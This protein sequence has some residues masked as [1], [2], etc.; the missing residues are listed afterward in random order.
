MH[1][2][3]MHKKFLIRQSLVGYV[4]LFDM[5]AMYVGALARKGLFYF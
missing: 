2:P 1:T 3:R 5:A 4:V